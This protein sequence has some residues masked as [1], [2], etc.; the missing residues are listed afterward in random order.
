MIGVSVYIAYQCH[1]SINCVLEVWMQTI[2]TTNTIFSTQMHLAA[3][4]CTSKIRIEN[5][6]RI[7]I[8][9]I[10]MLHKL[11]I[12]LTICVMQMNSN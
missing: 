8:L 4:C 9:S 12:V 7:D 3:Y 5:S 10:Y 2:G 11:S 6:Q 1:G